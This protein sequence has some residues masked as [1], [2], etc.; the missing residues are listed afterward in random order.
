MEKE[1]GGAGLPEGWS[2]PES[3]REEEP[4]QVVEVSGS[5]VVEAVVVVA[6]GV[7]GGVRVG[8]WVVIRVVVGVIFGV[9]D[10]VCNSEFE[11]L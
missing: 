8:F 6:G 5:S 11:S 9:V 4:S 2:A 3:I 1:I 7:L 10:G